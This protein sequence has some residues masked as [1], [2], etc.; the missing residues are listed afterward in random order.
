MFTRWPLRLPQVARKTTSA[1][2]GVGAED[3]QANAETAAAA[4]NFFKP[5][6]PEHIPFAGK[7]GVNFFSRVMGS[8]MAP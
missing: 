2:T 5:P 6:M 4:A 1:T 3:V 7:G 8:S